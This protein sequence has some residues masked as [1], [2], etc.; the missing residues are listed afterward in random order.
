MQ[1]VSTIKEVRSVI[2]GWRD[3]GER[4]AFV[5]T[6]GNLHEGHLAL[7]HRAAQLARRVVASIFVN[8]LQFGP[9]EDFNAY[10]RT[11]EEDGRK[12]RDA[13]LDLLFMPPAE[14]IYPHGQPL[15]RVEVQ[16]LSSILCG[17][18][19]PGHFAG[20]ATVVAKLLNVVQPDLA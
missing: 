14:E 2:A 19:R 12:L 5:P 7:V 10:P 11:P 6:M 17:A 9:S 15:T 18:F 16:G 20:V 8:P 1:T 4:V 13:G 3:R